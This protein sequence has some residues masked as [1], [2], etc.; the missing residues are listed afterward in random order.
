MDFLKKMFGR[1]EDSPITSNP[2]AS[3][4]IP[5]PVFNDK[6]LE[7]AEKIKA[8]LPETIK[9]LDKLGRRVEINRAK[10]AE[11]NLPKMLKDAWDKPGSLYQVISMGIDAAC[12][13]EV[14]EAAEHLSKTDT[15]P[16]RGAVVYSTALSLNGDYNTA[17]SV[18]ENYIKDDEHSP[19]A[20][21]A[22]A[23]IQL[24][25]EDKEA[26]AKLLDKSINLNP[27]QEQA[28]AW[29]LD[30][31]KQKDGEEAIDTE[32]KRLSEYEDSWFPQLI[33]GQRFMLADKTDDAISYYE[34]ALD[35]SDN[36]ANVLATATGD[37]GNKKMT[38]EL[39]SIFMPR[40]NP[41]TQGPLPGL[42]FVQSLIVEAQI[43]VAKELLHRIALFD[44][45]NIR[46]HVLKLSAQIAHID[47]QAFAK[48]RADQPSTSTPEVEF[49]K[50]SMPLWFY[51]LGEPYWLEPAKNEDAKRIYFSALHVDNDPSVKLAPELQNV[52]AGLCTAVPLFFKEAV[53]SRL[54]IRTAT[55]VPVM[56]DQGPVMRRAEWPQEQKQKIAN[57]DE[58]KPD[59]LVT[60]GIKFEGVDKIAELNL[61]L[62]DLDGNIVKTISEK[63][64]AKDL[65]LVITRAFNRLYEEVSGNTEA[66]FP[67]DIQA[68]LI[69]GYI[70]AL[71]HQLAY[72]MTWKGILPVEALFNRREL[73]ESLYAFAVN[74]GPAEMPKVFYFASLAYDRYL[75]GKTF[76]EQ[77][78]R[79]FALAQSAPQGTAFHQVA[80]IVL[81]I[82]N[83]LEQLEDI[84]K[85]IPKDEAPAPYINWMEGLKNLF[86]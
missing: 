79:A 57:L 61:Y 3:D 26:A 8:N 49:M 78:P 20:L 73:L 86:T 33:L 23:R 29:H 14:Q 55:L 40:Y 53:T 84:V 77:G 72:F 13:T 35:R 58:I 37:L 43:D 59:Y 76:M 32:L 9:T 41:D 15:N 18:L 83:R 36:N 67:K 69:Q 42:N 68:P 4:F 5:E 16:E 19:D 25:A 21:T 30:L 81:P 52:V 27:N 64:P 63:A 46:Q 44:Q 66:I 39:I 82:Y 85:Q 2:E 60:G 7:N 80:P 17:V 70:Q 12:F 54:D 45:A 50:I 75:A 24:M 28:M 48:A 1:P 31:I 71:G 51:P 65:H 47:R 34:K 62:N 22:L 11:T 6:L 10:W 38:K 74:S 56:K